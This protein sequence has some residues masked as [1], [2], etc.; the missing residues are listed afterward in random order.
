MS[1]PFDLEVSRRLPLADAAFRLLDFTLGPD[2]LAGV[3]ERHHGR[4]YEGTISFSLFVNLVAD[5]IFGQRG[6]AHQTFRHAQETDVLA[7]SI[8]AIYGKLRRVP[9]EL[10]LALFTEAAARLQSVWSPAAA[11]PLPKSFADFRCLGFDGKKLKYVAK[12]LK[13]LRGL[14]GNIFGGKLLVV[15]DMATQQAIAAEAAA[16]GEAADSPLVPGAVERVRALADNRAR[17]WVGDRAFCGY[18]LLTSLSLNADEFVIRYHASCHFE[19]DPTRPPRTGM[20]DEERP[21]RE[22][23]GWLGKSNNPYRIQVRKITV[24]RSDD[25]PLILV[26]SLLDAD[27]H[28]GEDVLTL[29]RSRWEIEVM[30]QQVVQTCNLR[31]LIGTTPEATVFQAM[32]CLLLYNVTLTVRDYVAE[33]AKVEPKQVSTKLLYDDLVRDLTGWLEVIG[34]EGTLELLRTTKILTAEELRRH[35]QNILGT[36]WTDLWKK[37]PT[38]KRPPRSEPRAYLRGGHSS[39]DKIIRGKHDEIPLK[40][41]NANPKPSKVKKPRPPTNKPKD[42]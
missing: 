9:L 37:S 12:R 25:E 40:P 23:W 15:Q 19:L 30:F 26:T 20:D 16:D 3:F 18:Q 35:L 33:G 8:Q 10:S 24:D 36:V 39:V 17:I 29:Y 28:P 27:R 22:E 42:V 11:N 32:L 14:N 5:A 21:F 38:V 13:P 4:S 41:K 31:H 1:S 34:V 6:S 7:A 2:F